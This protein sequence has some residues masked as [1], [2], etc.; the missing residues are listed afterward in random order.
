MGGVNGVSSFVTD[1][2]RPL[3]LGLGATGAAVVEVLTTLGAKVDALDVSEAAIERA[4]ELAPQANYVLA[5]DATDLAAQATRLAPRLVITSPGISPSTPVRQQLSLAGSEVISEIELARRLQDA[6]GFSQ[7]PWFAI[8]GTNGKT[9]TVRMLAAMLGAAGYRAPAVGNVGDPLVRVVAELGAA[10]GATA[11]PLEL[12]S[13]QLF[14]TQQLRAHGAVCL[15]LAPDHLDWHGSAQHYADAKARVYAGAQS[16]CVY[17]QDPAT[18]RMVEEADV[19]PGTRAIGV[20]TGVPTVGEL[21]VVEELLVDRAFLAK[22]QREARPFATLEDLAHLAGGQVPPRHLVQDALAAAALAFSAGASPEA[23]RQ[24]LTDFT[25]DAHRGDVV[26]EQDG[27][28]WVNNSKATNPHAARAALAGL[29]AGSAVWIAGG[30][31][32][33][34][35]LASLVHEVADRLRAVVIIGKDPTPLASAVGQLATPVAAV[36]VPDGSAEAVMRAAVAHAHRLAQPGDTVLL[37]PACA[38]WDQFSS[39]SQRGALFTAAAR[40]QVGSADA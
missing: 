14:D 11:I 36:V 7:V 26:A 12:S 19:A 5:R 6:G 29:A 31:S 32:K 2:A 28:R 23:V 30:D 3:V 35:E 40:E 33:G 18:R 8:T 37:A 25:P 1:L 9:T 34:T 27:V 21:G 15:N 38:S 16:V 20:T 4:R 39:Y 24:A 10:H 22:R 13:F 17:T